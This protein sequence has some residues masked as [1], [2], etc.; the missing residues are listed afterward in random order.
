MSNTLLSIIHPTRENSQKAFENVNKWKNLHTSKDLKIEYFL[1]I[2][3]LEKDEYLNQFSN[4]KNTDL[5]KIKYIFFNKKILQLKDIFKN[6]LP[7][8]NETKNY[9]TAINKT[10][11]LAELSKGEWLMFATD[12][13]YP[14]G[15]WSENLYEVVRKIKPKNEPV[16]FGRQCEAAKNLIS[17]PIMSK[18][19]Y[20]N[21]GYFFHP[22]YLHTFVD[23]D[24]FY[25]AT[26]LCSYRILPF[27]CSLWFT[28]ET[29]ELIEGNPQKVTEMY[30][31][32]EMMLITRSKNM[33]RYGS[34]IFETR[35]TEMGIPKEA[36][37]N[38]QEKQYMMEMIDTIIQK[39]LNEAP[40]ANNV[41]LDKIV[42]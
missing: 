4:F 31:Q 41:C 14:I 42:F 19:Y 3:D 8:E 30:N 18:K 5:F 29:Q 34:K 7:N 32:N 6:T 9:S 25:R 37:F 1:G 12:D 38:F 2:D 22:K 24:L 23:M 11:H 33:Q 40:E 26:H 17:H 16:I 27:A 15:K 39:K 20:D 13:F 10:N 36:V 28:H 21:E 35:R